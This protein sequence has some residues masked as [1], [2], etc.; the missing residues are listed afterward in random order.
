MPLY[1]VITQEGADSIEAKAK[2]AEEITRIHV[3]VMEVRRTL[4]AWSSFRIRRG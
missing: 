1:T 3:T 2:T 4:F